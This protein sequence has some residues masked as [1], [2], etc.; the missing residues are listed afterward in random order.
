[1]GKSRKPKKINRKN[2]KNIV[3]QQKLVAKNVELLKKIK[4]TA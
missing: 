2:R 3:K 1:M 4:E